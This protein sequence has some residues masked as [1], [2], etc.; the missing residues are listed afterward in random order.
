MSIG[1][2]KE[3]ETSQGARIRVIGIGGGGGNAVNNMISQ[4][5][6]GVDFIVA[7]TDVQALKCSLAPL[8]IQVGRETTRGLGAGAD[9]EIG[10][11]SL[12]ENIDEVRQSLSGS[13][14]IFITA[15]MGG[16]T[17]TGGAP[18]V[19]R[20]GRELGAL[21]VGV[22]T[23]PFTFEARKRMNVADKG[24]REL[25]EYVDALLVIPNQKLLDITDKKTTFKD[26]YMKVDQV[27]YNATRGIADIITKAGVV[28]VDFADVRTIMK[29][30]GDA[31]MGT[32]MAVGEN[33][34]IEATE[35][36]LNSPLLEG[37]TISGAQG[38]L[39][40]ITAPED[41][42][43]HEVNETLSIIEKSAGS[44]VNL[45]HGVVINEDG[46]NEYMVTVVA[47]GFNKSTVK[48][49]SET[50]EDVSSNNPDRPREH[51]K[52]SFPLKRDFPDAIK[53]P[54]TLA[55]ESKSSSGSRGS[56]IRIPKPPRGP[57]E[58]R[59][60]DKPAVERREF[61]KSERNQTAFNFD[62]TRTDT[63]D[64]NTGHS[65]AIISNIHNHFKK[66]NGSSKDKD[67]LKQPTFLRKMMD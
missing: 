43:L 10:R 38:V 62:D 36:A 3:Q 12:E 21:V 1:I 50:S 40:N 66:I 39:V 64:E 23:K 31:L 7:N 44:D 42:A 54:I 41:L 2:E 52:E 29:G 17:G 49:D 46:S 35:N 11:K 22:V 47:T 8:K 45:I 28:N 58:L 60:F 67:I 27:L 37:I 61:P 24:I 18:I 32:G 33:R 63:V 25:R 51:S 56:Q 65:K 26:A 15:G 53:P 55:N 6:D 30:M 13:D 57:D 48:K 34:A 14:M 59:E 9:P 4:G 19:S 5:L 16:G 20:I